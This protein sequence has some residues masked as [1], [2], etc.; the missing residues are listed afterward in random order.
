MFAKYGISAR[1]AL[2]TKTA[3]VSEGSLF[4]YFKTK[5]ELINALYRELRPDLA[6]AIMSDFPGA[7]ACAIGW[8]TYGCAG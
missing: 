8:S 3:K 2:I 5:D 6:S 7:P 4:T 1:T